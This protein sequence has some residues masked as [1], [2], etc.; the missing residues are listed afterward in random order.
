MQ[1]DKEFEALTR[2]HNGL[3]AVKDTLSTLTANAPPGQQTRDN[4]ARIC[5]LE[6]TLG[7]AHRPTVFNMRAQGEIIKQLENELAA[8]GETLASPVVTALPAVRSVQ[9]VTQSA[10]M[11]ALTTTHAAFS[12]LNAADRLQLA[13][14]GGKILG[15]ELSKFTTATLSLFF[16][17]GG[18][19]EDDTVKPTVRATPEPAQPARTGFDML[20]NKLSFAQDGTAKTRVEFAL[21]DDNGKME[22]CRNGGRVID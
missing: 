8:K 14:G 3:L 12:K 7:I 6:T 15:S 13:Q 9:A 1:P 2:I 18:K 5:E 10:D 21:L 20:G 17:D 19:V 16:R 4:I 11:G 22:F